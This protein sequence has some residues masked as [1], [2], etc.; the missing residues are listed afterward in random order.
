MAEVI[1]QLGGLTQAAEKTKIIRSL[2]ARYRDGDSDPTREKLLVI[3]QAA[4]VD[5]GWLAAGT[6]AQ[7]N[8]TM[9]EIGF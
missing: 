4:E 1:E 6:P 3:S 8:T 5:F 9:H 7:L 2:L